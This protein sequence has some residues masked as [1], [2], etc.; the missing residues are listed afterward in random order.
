MSKR[1]TKGGETVSNIATLRKAQRMTQAELAEKLGV[2]RSALAM[3]ECGDNLPP[4]K[5]LIAI[6]DILGCSLDELLREPKDG[7][8]HDT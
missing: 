1:A 2:S 5:Y 7:D 8:Q 3:W 4:T 6:C